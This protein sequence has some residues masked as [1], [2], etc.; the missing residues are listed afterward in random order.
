MSSPTERAP[1]DVPKVQPP[2]APGARLRA[3]ARGAGGHLLIA[4]LATAPMVLS[5]TRRL[6]GHPDVDVWN[7][8][9]GPW[10]FWVELSQGRL[11]LRTELL[12][13]PVGG[14]LWFPDP[15]GA[16]LGAP[17]VPL[18]GPVPAWNLVILLHLALAS[19]AGRRL[20]LSLSAS[21]GSGWL[22]GAALAC[23]PFLLSEVHN[24]I[25]E[26]VAAGPPVF[27][28]ALLLRVCQPG[29]GL[30]A[31]LGLGLAAGLTLGSSA[32]FSIGTAAVAAVLLPVALVRA[33]R[34]APSTAGFALLR[35]LISLGLALGVG[36][37]ML[38]AALWTLESDWLVFR[39]AVRDL[40]DMEPWFRHNAVDPRTFL[41]PGE[42]QSVDLSAEGFRHSSYLGLVLLP[43]ALLARRPAALLAAGAGLLLS[44]GP[45]L[46]WRGDWLLVDGERVMLPYRW[47]VD[48]LPAS[49]L[50]HP[51][52]VGLP[53]IAL[54]MAL[55]AVGLDRLPVRA[56]RA[57]AVLAL[58][59]LLLLSPAPWPLA[60]TPEVP[61]EAAAWL[62]GQGA[63]RG[64]VLLD[65]P[66]EVPPTM[67]SSR[68]LF[69]QTLHGL[70]IPY[71]P[72]VRAGT[73][74]IGGLRAY[75]WLV[76]QDRG[77]APGGGA[78]ELRRMRVGWVVVHR[79][80]LHDEAERARVEETLRAWAGEPIVR[81]AQAIWPLVPVRPEE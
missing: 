69:L 13:A 9:W 49:A 39:P 42:F 27:T 1:T 50:G 44:L 48:W 18:L 34:D 37:P 16:L 46:W 21:A 2:A 51:Q 73:A 79:D 62:R 41:W 56:R 19:A 57:L 81:G 28:L 24:G 17:L 36:L 67:R 55:A 47:L 11:P 78:D 10:W 64:L 6:L 52:R 38:R 65:L 30:R 29:A 63:G 4:L 26:A 53:A 59:D 40:L 61:G 23:S 15:I 12:A 43:L 31:V 68:H 22:G 8:A 14:R 60:R 75:R 3:L 66:A 20:A 58:A 72:D 35:L 80:L 7:H 71:K 5:P 70:P 32:Y 77:E 74:S 25:S 54:L 45:W 76:G 33:G